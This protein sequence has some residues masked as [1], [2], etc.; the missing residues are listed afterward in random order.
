M[1]GDRLP[2]CGLVFKVVLAVQFALV[3]LTCSSLFRSAW[4]G[5]HRCPIH[6]PA[7]LSSAVPS[8]DKNQHATLCLC[9]LCQQIKVERDRMQLWQEPGLYLYCLV[10]VLASDVNE[11]LLLA[12]IKEFIFLLQYL[13]VHFKIESVADDIM[14]MMDG[15]LQPVVTS[16]NQ[17]R[18]SVEGLLCI[19]IVGWY[20]QSGKLVTVPAI[21][22]PPPYTVMLIS[23]VIWHT[24]AQCLLMWHCS[25]GCDGATCD[26]TLQGSISVSLPV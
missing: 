7:G 23:I 22:I 4:R 19:N 8:Q 12:Y 25:G 5:E 1:K 26:L 15:C 6:H 14:V 2:V 21:S 18:F 9:A 17:D 24:V 11:S 13:F 16:V 10:V 3:G 20:R